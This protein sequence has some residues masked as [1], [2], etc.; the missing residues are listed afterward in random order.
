MPGFAVSSDGLVFSAITMSVSVCQ[1]SS[2]DV[3]AR[4]EATSLGKSPLSLAHS[5][6]EEDAAAG[7]SRF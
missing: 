7:N 5:S 1:C 2:L 6:A 3:M 4:Q